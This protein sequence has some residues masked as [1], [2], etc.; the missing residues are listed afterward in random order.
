M[1]NPVPPEVPPPVLLDAELIMRPRLPFALRF[2]DS[3][4]EST[5]DSWLLV[6]AETSA[7]GCAGVSCFGTDT[8]GLKIL[9]TNPN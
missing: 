9:L 3:P 8:F 4:L 7:A 6:G 2:K 5:A 1:F